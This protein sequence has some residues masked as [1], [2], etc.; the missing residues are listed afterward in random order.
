M[1]PKCEQKNIKEDINIL[2]IV[3]FHPTH[4]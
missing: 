4:T 1:T 3:L 2:K